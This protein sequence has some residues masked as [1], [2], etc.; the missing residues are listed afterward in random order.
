MKVISLG[1]C[2]EKE[3][4][5]AKAEAGILHLCKHKYVVRVLDTFTE[6]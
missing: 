2:E 4:Q 6:G 5:Y 1:D 3:L